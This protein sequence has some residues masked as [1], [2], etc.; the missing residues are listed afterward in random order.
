MDLRTL[1]MSIPVLCAC[2]PICG[3]ILRVG[4]GEHFATPHEAV[5]VVTNGDTIVIS[6]GTY[7]FS[8]A[9][10][11]SD[12]EE[13]MVIGD[14]DVYLL[15][16]NMED[17]VFWISGC[18]TVAIRNV[19]ARHTD[20]GEDE[21]CYGNVFGIDTSDDIVIANCEIHGCG[22]IGVY[23]YN[24]NNVEIRDNHIHHNRFWAVQFEGVG[25]LSEDRSVAGLTMHGNT[26]E[27][28]GCEED[29]VYAEGFSIASFIGIEDIDYIYFHFEDD[30]TGDTLQFL[31]SDDC[32]ECFPILHAPDSYS[33][34]TMEV[35]WEEVGILAPG[36]EECVRM[37]RIVSILILD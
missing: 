11:L 27:H 8:N 4:E 29:V 16:D 6:G 21:R 5:A 31:V 1:L 37:K 25:L 28:N 13:V 33:G 36:T 19:H 3:S 2:S 24:S 9:I 15:C 35:E 34:E 22:A 18:R 20:P 23:A 12:L 14:G 7:R 26:M 10:T 17:T 30:E 32:D